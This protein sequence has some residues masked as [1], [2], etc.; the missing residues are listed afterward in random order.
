MEAQEKFTYRFIEERRL[1]HGWNVAEVRIYFDKGKSGKN[2]DRPELKRLRRDIANGEINFV[3]TFKLDRITRSLRDFVEL[4][5]FFNEH[6]VDVTSIRESFDTSAPAGKAM[7][8]ILMV[9]AELERDMNSERTKSTIR[10]RTENGQWGG[11]YAFG[12][13]KDPL[14]DK[15]VPH[16]VDSKVVKEHF[17]DAFETEGSVGA[18]LRRLNRLGIQRPIQRAVKKDAS[19]PETDQE[20]LHRAM[21]NEPTQYKPFEKQQVSR[22][23]Q[24]VLYRGT[25]Q[26]GDVTTEN[27][28]EPLIPP[29]QFERVQKK[30]AANTARRQN[31][32]Y[33]RGRVY[34]LNS[35]LR[36]SCGAHLYR[37]GR[38]GPQQDLRLLRM[39]PPDSSRNE[40]GMCGPSLS[41]RRPGRGRHVTCPTDQL[42]SRNASEDR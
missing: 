42:E 3:V 26:R 34:L 41:R 10:S 39:H 23:L 14:T 17:F 4:W 18:V 32:R 28:H 12:Y 36:C 25:I 31:T 20:L 7:L 21:T 37:Q 5:D 27:A 13:I 15:L 35:L 29:E 24:N 40:D 2:T 16:P 22:I 6:G 33:S 9:F 30:M 8:G 38:H 19:R 1:I 11:G